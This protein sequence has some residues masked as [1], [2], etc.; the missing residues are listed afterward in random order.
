MDGSQDFAFDVDI[1]LEAASA[2]TGLTDFGDDRFRRGL[3]ALC[4]TLDTTAGLT[5]LGRKINWKR[6]VRLLATRLRVEAAFHRHPEIQEREIRRPIFLTGLPRSGT[7]ATFNLLGRDP[8]S[9][10]LL[11]WE[12]TFPD[13]LEGLAA[14]QPDPRH[15]AMKESFAKMREKNPDF[16]KIHF[17]DADTPEE[18]VIPMAITLQNVHQGFEVLLEPY[19]SY[20]YALDLHPQYADYRE[21]LKM[22]DWQR[23]GE[24]WLLKSPAH[25]LGLDGLLA[26]FPDCGIVLN[27][28]DPV[29]AVA[30][31]C[32]MMET[33]ATSQ[34]C[35]RQPNLGQA[36]LKFCATALERGL[37]VRDREDPRR[38][39]DIR[40][41]DLVADAMGAVTR[42]YDHF[43]LSLSPE[44]E[45]AMSDHI[46]GNPRGQ[47]GSHDYD[48]SAYG[49]TADEVRERMQWYIDRFELDV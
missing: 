33:F 7:S 49:L 44:A 42:L 28:R 16:T 32:S 40:F 9:R 29:A 26:A 10:P 27:H 46:R 36:V 22:L 24:R 6:L 31:Y 21:L 47:H 12:G 18:C 14:G 25:L 35:S 5:D 20:F 4:E 41:D 13:P 3:E 45:H 8:A 19:G 37:A 23:P 38:F 1:L 34:G 39:F 17:A 11:L 43:E 48:L 15:A 30:S 2:Q